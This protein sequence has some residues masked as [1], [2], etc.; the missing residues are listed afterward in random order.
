KGALYD[1]YADNYAWGTVEL[2][3][4]AGLS[5][6]APG[7]GAL[8]AG[9]FALDGGLGQLASIMSDYNIYYDPL[10][11][12]N[13]YL[14]GQTYA[15]TG[16]GFLIP[17]AVPEPEIYASL[18]AGFGLIGFLARRRKRLRSASRA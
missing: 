4:S 11:A 17:T 12:G 1:G 9:V 2:A 7:N 8:Y 13:S 6:T 16:A 14:H 15:L 3:A 5:I 18:L 10:L